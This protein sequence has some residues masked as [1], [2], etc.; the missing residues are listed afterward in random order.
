MREKKNSSRKILIIGIII[1]FIGASAVSGFSLKINNQTLSESNS[2]SV[3]S[4]E[5]TTIDPPISQIGGRGDDGDWDYWTNPPH[6]FSNVTGNVGIG[7]T[8][9]TNLLHIAGSDLVPLVNIEQSGTHRGLRVNTTNACAI[10]VDH[11]GNHG[12]RITDA[13]GDGVHITSAGGDGVYVA[14]AGG[15]AGYFNGD[16]FFGG[17]VG[18]G[19]TTP[20]S[21]LEVAGIIHSSSGGFEF[22]DG[23]IQTSAATGGSAGNTLDQAYDQGGSGTGRTITADSG[24]VNIIGSDGLTVSG[25]VGINTTAPIHELDVKGEVRADGYIG[26]DITF[27]KDGMDVW[28]IYADLYYLYLQNTITGSKYIFVLAAAGN[29]EGSTQSQTSSPVTLEQE[30]KNLK[31]ENEELQQRINNLERAINQIFNIKNI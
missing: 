11:A 5:T 17:D 13:T 20:D 8:N 28:R 6:M 29:I 27:M 10:W 25:N 22:P 12:L 18:I 19:T 3:V 4:E 30:I 2:P 21:P 24:A 9:P 7:T 16:G 31:T 1:L 15:W 23:T 26:D 14:S